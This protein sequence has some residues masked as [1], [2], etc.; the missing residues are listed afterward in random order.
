LQQAIAREEKT[1]EAIEK[2]V[3]KTIKRAAAREELAREKAARQAEKEVKKAQKTREAELRKIKIEKR[4][5]ERMQAKKSSSQRAKDGE[6][7]SINDD[8]VDKSRKRV[9]FVR[10]HLRNQ[11]LAIKLTPRLDSTAI[12]HSNDTNGD[13]IIATDEL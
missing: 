1:R 12:E 6:K 11:S 9:R 13:A 7:R 10:S 3:K 4:R 5:I 2:K 8:E